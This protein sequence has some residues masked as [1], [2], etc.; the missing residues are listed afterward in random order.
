MRQKRRK[1]YSLNR[2]LKMAVVAG[3]SLSLIVGCSAISVLTPERNSA[4][5]SQTDQAVKVQKITKQKIAEPLELSAEVTSSV[6]IDAVAKMGGDIEQ[7]L[8]K[9]GDL[10]EEG[11]VIIKLNSTESKRQRDKALLAVQSAQEALETGRKDVRN[12]KLELDYSVQKLE[13]E[14]EDLTRNYNKM[15][16]DYDRG[17]GTKSQLNQ[18][19]T[20]L[21]KLRMDLDAMKQ[22]QRSQDSAGVLSSLQAQLSNAQISLQQADQAMTYLEVKSPVSGILT[23]LPVIAGMTLQ[24]GSKVGQIMKLDP[25]KIKA[26][27]N[28]E[29]A[30]IAREKNEITYFRPGTEQKSKGKISFLS[31]VIDPQTKAYELNLEV[32]NKDTALKPGM[33]LRIQVTDE[34]EQIVT[35]VPQ[36]SIVR[37]AGGAAFV[38]VSSGDNI[39]EKRKV[40]L[41]RSNELYVEILSGV[42]EGETLVV[43][44]QEQL[45]DK[46]KIRL[47]AA[48][49]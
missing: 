35:A 14:L 40:Q 17:T 11:E 41:G 1:S 19:E 48:E 30:K 26:L 37:E 42:K 4:T 31:T 2:T 32:S 15:K 9:R 22:K 39:V 16:N 43:T 20:Q 44:G 45:K 13:L 49:S 12:S 18:T 47:A 36:Q 28:E 46:D 10:I 25:I 38:F 29:A 3:L 6:Q 24:A 33:K 5:P 23:E 21:K 8:K 7:I 27:L 34:S